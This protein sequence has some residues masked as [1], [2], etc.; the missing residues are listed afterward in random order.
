MGR[1]EA[2]GLGINCSSLEEPSAGSWVWRQKRG[3]KGELGLPGEQTL[4]GPSLAFVCG[5]VCDTAE[6]G[7]RKQHFRCNT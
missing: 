3:R 2:A 5:A 4:K 7:I 6:V 1:C